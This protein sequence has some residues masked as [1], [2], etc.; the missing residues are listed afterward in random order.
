MYGTLGDCWALAN[1][2]S[3]GQNGQAYIISPLA[4]NN[5]PA[6]FNGKK[7]TIFILN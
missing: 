4:N 1:L 3:L 5:I 2:G 6:N 7:E